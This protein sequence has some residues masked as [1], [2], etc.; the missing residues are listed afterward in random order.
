[1]VRMV[2]TASDTRMEEEKQ[3]EMGR[4]VGSLAGHGD[5]QLLCGRDGPKSSYF[6]CGFGQCF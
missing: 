2:Q 1:M 4:S 5:V 3:G 6:G